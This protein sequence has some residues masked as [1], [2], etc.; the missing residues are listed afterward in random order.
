M[1]AVAS[2]PARTPSCETSTAYRPVAR[3]RTLPLDI[4]HIKHGLPAVG[5]PEQ[6]AEELE[7]LE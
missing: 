7:Q 4:A 5:G 6:V 3:D 2:P 1:T